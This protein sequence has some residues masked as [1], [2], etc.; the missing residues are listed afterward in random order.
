MKNTFKIIQNKNV[1]GVKL[2]NTVIQNRGMNLGSDDD[3]ICSAE[4]EPKKEFINKEAPEG[5]EVNDF[6]VSTLMKK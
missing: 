6:K 2:K 5:L 3:W 1:V 4:E